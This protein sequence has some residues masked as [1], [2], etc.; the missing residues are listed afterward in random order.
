MVPLYHSDPF[1]VVRGDDACL[2]VA[3]TNIMWELS[4][5]S[6]ILNGIASNCTW[7]QT[8]TDVLPEHRGG[9][10]AVSLVY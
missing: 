7:P 4:A 8:G 5:T 10:M 2:G 1:S 9:V 6:V 3:S